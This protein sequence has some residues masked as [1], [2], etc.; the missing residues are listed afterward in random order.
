MHYN[1]IFEPEFIVTHRDQIKSGGY[2]IDTLEAV[3]WSVLTT[4]T[5]VKAVYKA[6][7]LGDDTDTIGAISGALAGALYGYESIPKEWKDVLI[8]KEFIEEICQRCCF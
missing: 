3:L 2:I 1:R 8:K 7:N 5:Y 6:V 4:N